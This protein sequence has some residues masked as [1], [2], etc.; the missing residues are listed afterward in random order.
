M[1]C[2]AEFTSPTCTPST[3][4][5]ICC[6]IQREFAS[7]RTVE[8]NFEFTPGQTHFESMARKIVLTLTTYPPLVAALRE[9]R[10]CFVLATFQ[11]LDDSHTPRFIATIVRTLL[12]T[13]ALHSVPVPSAELIAS[14]LVLLRKPQLEMLL[15]TLASCSLSLRALRP[16][17]FQFRGSAE[18]RLKSPT[19]STDEEEGVEEECGL[20]SALETKRRRL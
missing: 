15:A 18:P 5:R 11:D 3:P 7:P 12:S 10:F 17:L 8:G 2:G 4:G 14:T 20:E 9:S 6:S 16:T 1:I 19:P 13:T